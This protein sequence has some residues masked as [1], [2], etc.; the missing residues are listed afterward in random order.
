VRALALL[1]L[2]GCFLFPHDPQRC[3]EDRVAAITSQDDVATFAG[4]R[5]VL[6]LAIRTG[7]TIDLAPL[8]DLE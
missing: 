1:P 5:R 2:T 8:R 4:C 3:R 6:G 7:Q